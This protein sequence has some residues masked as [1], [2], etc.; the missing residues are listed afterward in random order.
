MRII[1]REVMMFVLFSLI[2]VL[3]FY[4]LIAGKVIEYGV[5][6]DRKR[7]YEFIEPID[8]A[9][10]K[11]EGKQKAYYEYLYNKTK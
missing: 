4:K 6:M 9:K 10:N 8:Y 11:Q 3:L 7:K 1:R 2:L 5:I